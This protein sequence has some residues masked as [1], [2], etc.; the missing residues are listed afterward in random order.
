MSSVKSMIGIAMLCV[1]AAPLATPA[2]EG[3]PSS[4]Y[5]G[6]KGGFIEPD[7]ARSDPALNIGG[8]V[9]QRLTRWIGWEGELSF[10]AVDGERNANRDW[11]TNTLAGYAVFRTPGPVFFKARGGLAYWDADHGDDLD[12]SASLGGGF[13]LGKAAID[14]EY[15]WIDDELEYLSG[16]FLFNF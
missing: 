11:S 3:Y 14:I 7:A 10:T 5:F 15:T 12:L 2:Q 13:R 4:I 16:A 1:A 8:V 9:G 6:P